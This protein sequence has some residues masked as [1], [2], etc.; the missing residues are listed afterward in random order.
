MVRD[1]ETG[2]DKELY[3]IADPAYFPGFAALSP[4]GLQLAIVEVADME[5]P[6]VL[7]VIPAAGGESRDLLR[8]VQL[9]FPAQ[10]AWTPDGSSLLFARQSSPHNSKTELWLISVQSGE[11]RKLDLAADGMRYIC[12][13]PDGRHIAFTEVKNKDEVWVMENFLPPLKDVK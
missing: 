5:S 13:H 8:G 1:L 9:P 3:C 6:M 12:L 4:D 10:T 11:Q 7:K 2:E